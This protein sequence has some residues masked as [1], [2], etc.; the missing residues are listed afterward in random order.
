[1]VYRKEVR[2]GAYCRYQC[3]NMF[4]ATKS[5]PLVSSHVFININARSSLMGDDT[6][7]KKPSKPLLN[8]SHVGKNVREEYAI[9]NPFHTCGQHVVIDGT[10]VKG[11]AFIH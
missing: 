3:R 1:V 9:N 5:L 7:R 4:F 2:R 8:R 11:H 10:S 6:S